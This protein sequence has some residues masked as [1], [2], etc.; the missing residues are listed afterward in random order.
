MILVFLAIACVLSVPL[1]GGRLQRLAGVDLRFLWTAPLAVA[2]QVVILVIATG[3]NRSLHVA[4][5]LAT[6]ALVGVFIWA[7]RR[8][9]G[10][11]LIGAG[12]LMNVAAIVANGGV[13]P[14]SESAQMISG[15]PHHAGFRNVAVLAHPHLLWLGDIIPVPAGMFSNVFS[16]GDLVLLAGMVVLMHRVCRGEGDVLDCIKRL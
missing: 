7:N 4:I 11:W 1:T 9:P 3:G 6:Y 14:R 12:T 5:H 8:L 2:L 16:I 13:M 15:P 10:S